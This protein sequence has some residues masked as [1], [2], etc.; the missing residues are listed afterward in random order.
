MEITR[1]KIEELAP[2][3]NAAKNGRALVEKNKLSNL[4][5]SAD[6]TL[7]W[8]ECA[9]SGSEPYLCSADYVDEHHPVFRCT[10]PV[11]QL[12]CKHTLG[13]LYA[14]EKALPFTTADIPADILSKREKIEQ[15]QQKK[16][17]DKEARRDKTA[18]P[19]PANK[20]AVVKKIDAQLAGVELAGRILTNIIRNGLL[21]IDAKVY[22]TLREQSR[23]LGN[24]YVAGIQN[25]FN[26]L[27]QE[28]ENVKNDE[29]TAVIDRINYISAL[30]RKSAE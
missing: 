19:K 16:I 17:A 22:G 1:M 11:R 3:P 18:K 2:N 8:G 9:G 15:H 29:Y 27:W 25:A 30:L 7:I 10:C 24:Y 5:I 26:N 4:R 12:P 28:L 21:S 20:N 13:L 23:E 14:Y 6:R